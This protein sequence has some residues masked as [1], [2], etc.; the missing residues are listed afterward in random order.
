MTKEVLVMKLQLLFNDDHSLL[1][2]DICEIARKCGPDYSVFE[3]LRV[4]RKM[5]SEK[6]IEI[7]R[8]AANE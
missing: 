3:V 7:L 5:K 8:K 4:I 1:T 2:V 6:E